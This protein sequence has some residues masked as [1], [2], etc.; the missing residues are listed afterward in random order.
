MIVETILPHSQHAHNI[1]TPHTENLNRNSHSANCEQF[2]LLNI[3]SSGDKMTEYL[4]DIV[5]LLDRSGREK[6]KS[7]AHKWQECVN[8]FAT[9]IIHSYSV[10]PNHL[11]VHLYIFKFLY[12]S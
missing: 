1:N 7:N 9:Y 4:A 5:I 6:I 11:Y 8:A 10:T 3:L 12:P 2:I